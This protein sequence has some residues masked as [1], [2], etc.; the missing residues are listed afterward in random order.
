MKEAGRATQVSRERFTLAL[1]FLVAV[2][3]ILHLWSINAAVVDAADTAPITGAVLVV[4]AVILGPLALLTRSPHRAAL[5]VAVVWVPILTFGYQLGFVRDRFPDVTNDVVMVANAAAL[6]G[7]VALVW[8]LDLNRLAAYA[9]VAVAIFCATTLP[10][11]AVGLSFA[12]QPARS[13]VDERVGGPDIYF[14]VLDGYGRADV[15]QKLYEHDNQPF[16]DDLQKR[17]F[18]VADDSY[19]NYAMTYLSLAATLN[20]EYVADD[21]PADYAAVDRLIE[22]GAVIRALQ[23]RGYQYIHFETE[24]WATANA[25]LADITYRRGRF[26]SEFERAFF[27]TTLL[28]TVLPPRPRHEAVMNTLEDL[29][30]IPAMPAPTFTFA[31]LLVPHPPFMFDANGGVIPYADDLA[32]G[33]EK[34]PYVAQL[35][36]VNVEILSLVDAIRADSDDQPVII[37]QGDHGPAAFLTDYAT[38][39]DIYW[40]RHGV[41]NAILVPDDIRAELYPSMSPVNTFRLLLTGLFDADLPPLPDRALYNWYMDGNHAA[42]A[43]DPLKLRDITDLLP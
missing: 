7:L 38:P 15:L 9:T 18:Y 3:P 2:A 26:E 25:P 39:E 16:L 5:T 20:M 32:A 24:W 41:L 27:D 10:G 12:A 1:P 11:L 43:G 30:K 36:Y 33:F 29:R 37:I 21:L 17:G 13:T 42:I 40:E 8:R 22:D 34:D 31:H 6:V 4:T 14:I 19:S 35:R 28:G 23:R